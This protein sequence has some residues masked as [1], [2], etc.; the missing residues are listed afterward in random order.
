M[1]LL[2]SWE[3]HPALDRVSPVIVLRALE[4]GGRRL[5]NRRPWS[6]HSVSRLVKVS[7][8]CC[9]DQA[10]PCV[11]AKPA[12]QRRNLMLHGL[13]ADAADFGDLFIRLA[14]LDK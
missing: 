6:G 5:A 12:E 1:L 7:L 9:R 13:L 4:R 14:L 8:K 2:G 3:R 10:S 11:H